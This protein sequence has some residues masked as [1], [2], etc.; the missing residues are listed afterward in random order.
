MII[1][2][3]RAQKINYPKKLNLYLNPELRRLT[4]LYCLWVRGAVGGV[5]KKT[6]HLQTGEG[7]NIA[8]RC[9]GIKSYLKK[10]TRAL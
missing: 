10:V 3:R 8:S 5:R 6:S 9:H 1:R 4:P 7:C 2:E